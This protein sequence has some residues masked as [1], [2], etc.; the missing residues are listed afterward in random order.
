M[1]GKIKYLDQFFS[2]T[3]RY[4]YE[5]LENEDSTDFYVSLM[6]RNKSFYSKKDIKNFCKVAESYAGKCELSNVGLQITP[7]VNG[8]WLRVDISD[9]SFNLE[10][11]L[12]INNL[13]AFLRKINPYLEDFS[14]NSLAKFNKYFS[15]ETNLDNQLSKITFEDDT[16]Y[17]VK[18]TLE[19][20]KTYESEKDWDLDWDEELDDEEMEHYLY[21]K[22]VDQ[23]IPEQRKET[24][25]IEEYIEFQEKVDEVI[26]RLPSSIVERKQEKYFDTLNNYANL[27]WIIYD[28]MNDAV[29]RNDENEFEKARED[30]KRVKE[31]T[32]VLT[33]KK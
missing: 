6:F 23:Y 25:K 31:M 13:D 28:N 10:D 21:K 5:I 4:R 33:Y 2:P 20:N 9:I 32:N 29:D 12:K 24:K 11:T 15:S 27:L 16:K 3:S 17:W 22:E 8:E 19:G 30:L 18:K 26:N 7:N 14:T 1:N